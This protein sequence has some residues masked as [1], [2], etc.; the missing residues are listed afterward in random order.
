VTRF[1][2]AVRILVALALPARVMA[3]DRSTIDRPDERLGKQVHVIYAVPSDGTD[4]SLDVN[5]TLANSV[6]AFEDWLASK[7]GGRDVRLD[8]S[9]GTLDVS[10]IRLPDTNDVIKAHGFYIR[11]YLEEQ[12]ELAGFTDPDKLYATYYDGE[13]DVACGGGAWP[14]VLPGSVAAIYLRGLPAGP[15][16]C[17]ANPFAGAGEPPT[18]LEFAMLHEILHTLGFVDVH[19]TNEVLS[20]HVG[21]DPDDL[22]W[23]GAGSWIPSGW[24]AVKLDSGNDDYYK[25][26]DSAALDFDDSDFLVDA[27]EVPISADDFESGDLCHWSAANPPGCG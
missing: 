17:S 14:P 22:M 13:S 4:R 2:L 1:R 19:A 9:A 6:G 18:Y 25:H 26:S 3:L 23:A 27:S 5:G 15:V 8:T 21:D 20:G 24:A 11:D 10:F 16:P 7:A 12:L